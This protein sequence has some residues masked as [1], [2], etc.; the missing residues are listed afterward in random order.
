[1][2]EIICDRTFMKDGDRIDCYC[3]RTPLNTSLKLIIAYINE[4]AKQHFIP[5]IG[6]DYDVL[7]DHIDTLDIGFDRCM[8]VFSVRRP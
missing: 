2:T 7:S 8:Q 3:F 4:W 6:S 1:M 5:Q